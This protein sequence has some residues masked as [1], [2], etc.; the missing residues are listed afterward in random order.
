MS[1]G[2]CNTL[3]SAYTKYRHLGQYFTNPTMFTLVMS[4]YISVREPPYVERSTIT[5]SFPTGFSGK[6]TLQLL[7]KLIEKFFSEIMAYKITT[8]KP[9]SVRNIH[10]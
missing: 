8:P 5:N 9:F 1:M 10:P 7:Y 4:G 6:S 2:E 3:L